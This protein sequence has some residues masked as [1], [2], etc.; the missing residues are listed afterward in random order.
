MLRNYV[1]AMADQVGQTDRVLIRRIYRAT[2]AKWRTAPHA[3]K[4]HF[5]E[6]Q[7]PKAAAPSPADR[8]AAFG[9][10]QNPAATVLVPEA[11]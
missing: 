3:L 1:D 2:K 7:L 8:L 5:I 11:K 10:M 4:R 9:G 6:V